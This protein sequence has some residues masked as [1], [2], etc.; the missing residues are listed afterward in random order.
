MPNQIVT[1][2]MS[3]EFFLF[4]IKVNIT[5]KIDLLYFLSLFPKKILFLYTSI[6]NLIIV[7]T[8]RGFYYYHWLLY[9]YLYPTKKVAEPL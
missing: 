4:I 1:V 5:M 9:I 6:L 7:S 3:L 8:L 2:S